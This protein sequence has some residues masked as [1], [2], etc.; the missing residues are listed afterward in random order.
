MTFKKFEELFHQKYPD[1]R[2]WM[3]DKFE[4]GVPGRRQKVAV[5]FAPKGKVYMYSGAYEDI[6]CKVG[7]KVISKGR[8][9]ELL[10]RR[11]QLI[12]WNGTDNFFG[13]VMDTSKEIAEIEA[14]VERIERECIIA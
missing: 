2:V 3:H 8:F 14:E 11:E 9:N 6:L 5:E 10:A 12:R 4:H 1:G 13:G 7:I